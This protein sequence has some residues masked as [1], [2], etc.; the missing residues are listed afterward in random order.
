MALMI[1]VTIIILYGG[2]FYLLS[3]E[4]L[5]VP[6]FPRL[7][8]SHFDSLVASRN[9]FIRTLQQL[10]QRVVKTDKVNWKEEGF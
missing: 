9:E 6:T 10:E 4:Y 2:N 8:S 3:H 1:L 5:K 7:T